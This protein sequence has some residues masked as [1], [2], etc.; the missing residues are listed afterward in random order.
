MSVFS[1]CGVVECGV[2]VLT[3]RVA[4]LF[5]GTRVVTN[6]HG[7]CGNCGEVCFQCRKVRTRGAA[8]LLGLL[9]RLSALTRAN[10]GDAQC[11]HINYDRLD[12][13]LCTECGYCASGAFAFELTA[14]IASNAVAIQNDA[15]CE[16]ACRMLGVAA[17]LHQ[18]LRSTL[19]DTVAV[20]LGERDQPFYGGGGGTISSLSSP[21]V[22]S[23]TAAALRRALNGM[24]PLAPGEL[25]ENDN[26][27]WSG[28]LTLNKLGKQGSVVKAV[29]RSDSVSLMFGGN[30]GSRS[31]SL[32]RLTREWRESALAGSRRS[33]AGGGGG[34]SGDFILHHLSRDMDE[35]ESNEVFGLL[36]GRSSDDP[37][38]RLLASMQSRRERRTAAAAAS[39]SSSGPGSSPAPGSGGATGSAVAATTNQP[40]DSGAGSGSGSTSAA[41]TLT[42]EV[43]ELCDR[44]YLLMREA[45]REAYHLQLRVDAWRR[46]ESG[47]LIEYGCDDNG[48]DM[49]EEREADRLGEDDPNDAH[50]DRTNAAVHH[51]EPT[52]CSACS[53]PVALHLLNLWLALL[54][55][56]PDCVEVS[57]DMIHRLLGLQEPLPHSGGW[58]AAAATSLNKGWHDVQVRALTEIAVH[59]PHGSSL[60]LDALRLRL[61]VSPNPVYSEILGSIIEEGGSDAF[62]A[63]AHDVLQASFDADEF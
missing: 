57:H 62:V 63:L 25:A 50:V 24:L 47:S 10:C 35:E 27:A 34:G 4:A 52:Q 55:L 21:Q 8:W 2:A 1:G 45:E 20:A 33:G 53:G 60:V 44:L 29:A 22:S 15:D 61:Q 5:V 58:P 9:P 12:A 51:F 37:L 26:E 32:M 49:E 46:L 3:I 54:K 41:P 14:A 39:S 23:V 7:V 30:S 16:Q 17:R 18:D 42:K 38:S 6:A 40:K 31:Q 36:E 48:E 19:R 59:S 11:R 28:P 13:F 43:Q 56:Q